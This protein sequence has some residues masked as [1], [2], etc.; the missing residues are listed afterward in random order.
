M[1]N[2]NDSKKL[3]LKIEN[4]DWGGGVRN[5][6]TWY[7]YDDLSVTC[8][9]I[10]GEIKEKL[11]SLNIS[12]E[13]LNQIIENIELAKSDNHEI[14]AVD[15][16]AWEFIQYKN[17]SIIWKRKLGYIYGIESLEKIC[18]IL[19]NLVKNDSD[20]F[21]GEKEQN[22]MNY[23][24]N[25]E[26]NNQKQLNVSNDIEKNIINGYD[27]SNIIPTN[28]YI[29]MLVQYCEKVSNQYLQLINQDEEKNE[30]LKYDFKYYQYGKIY[31]TGLNVVIFDKSFQRI[32]YQNFLSYSQAVQ[33]RQVNNINS[34]EVRL[35]INFKRGQS[36]KTKE[37]NN[38]FIV[39]FKP[40]EIKF[41]RKSN[42]D[43][44]MMNQV[45]KD[46]NELL[47]SFPTVD[48]IF[49]TKG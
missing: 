33:N 34:M 14:Q 13:K 46:I 36:G 28:E 4:Q 25:A 41:T 48:T 10:I 15:G 42:F 16:E 18:N 19:H 23:N 45:E 39:K 44:N 11:Y 3:I 32:E 24:V 7:I 27:Y 49:C 22:N 2:I 35:N 47:R 30:K 21:L 5:T 12:K 17:N 40:Y 6:Q 8:E 9:S 20:I 29:S 37:H 43:D 1:N 26:N 38:E 31:G